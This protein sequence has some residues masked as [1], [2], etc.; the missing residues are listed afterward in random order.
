MGFPFGMSEKLFQNAMHPEPECEAYLQDAQQRGRLPEPEGVVN[1]DRS[2]ARSVSCKEAAFELK[3]EAEKSEKKLFRPERQERLYSLAM[4]KY[5]SNVARRMQ[6]RQGY[7][8]RQEENLQ[9][10]KQGLAR[11]VAWA[12]EGLDS[13]FSWG[14][15]KVVFVAEPAFNWLLAGIGQ[16]IFGSSPALEALELPALEYGSKGPPHIA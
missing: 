15:Q 3:I 4:N 6:T 10:M 5:P 14:A 16:T 7:E 9:A 1:K 12:W 13:G 11:A 8:K 2:I